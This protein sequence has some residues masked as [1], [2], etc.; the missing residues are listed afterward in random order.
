[1]L[2]DRPWREVAEFA[3]YVCQTETLHL[4]PCEEPPV[5]ADEAGDGQADLLLK[6]M[7]D[8]GVSRYH[9]DP[10]AALTEAP[11]AG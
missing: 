3:A 8:A 10:L 11:K 7:L 1:M 4:K 2:K 9:P 6:R 5:H